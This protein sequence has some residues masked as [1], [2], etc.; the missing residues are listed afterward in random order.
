MIRGAALTTIQ[1]SP[2]L[3]YD[4]ITDVSRMGEW[5]PECTGG[6]WA[7]PA[8]GP[9]I[10]AEFVGHN[11]AKL[12]PLTLKKWTTNSLV[13]AA[14]PGELFEFVSA[15]FTTWRYE[16]VGIDGATRVTE[17]FQHDPYTGFQNVLYERIL[18]RSDSM[19][20]AMEETLASLKRAIESDPRCHN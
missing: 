2:D 17:S 8:D 5:S 15:D 20:S 12:G 18:S 9:V 14:T 6:E 13:T 7:P 19:V 3:V 11:I 1:C 16:L 4:T 10:G